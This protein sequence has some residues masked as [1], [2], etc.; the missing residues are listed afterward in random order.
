MILLKQLKPFFLQPLPIISGLLVSVWIFTDFSERFLLDKNSKAKSDINFEQSQLHP[1]NISN[2]QQQSIISLYKEYKSEDKNG[3]S[4]KPEEGLSAEAQQQQRG[5]LNQVFAGDK[6]LQLKAVIANDNQQ[7]SLLK[8][9]L[10]VSDIKTGESNIEQFVNNT[11]LYGYTL[12]IDNNTQVTL[13]RNSEQ[14][15]QK[16]ILVMYKGRR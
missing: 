16:I 7:L 6:K 14:G 5:I 9:L 13:S 12:T 8:A 1:I 4:T 15:I 2:E 10:L 3:S 11:Q